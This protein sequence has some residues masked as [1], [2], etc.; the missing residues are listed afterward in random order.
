MVTDAGPGPRPGVIPAQAAAAGRALRDR[1]PRR[2][3][4]A[5]APRPDRPDPV[6]RILADDID[7]LP[8]LLALRHARLAQDPFAY[9]R[10]TAGLMAADL[11][12]SPVT[13]LQVQLCGD[14][15]VANF[16]WFASPERNLVF[17]VTD[18][19]ETLPGPWELDVRRL[20]ASVAVAAIVRGARRAAARDAAASAAAG[21]RAGIAEYAA[22]GTLEAWYA[23]VAAREVVETLRRGS[24]RDR[25][26]AQTALQQAI[27]HDRMAAVAQLTSVMPEG[28]RFVEQPPLVSRDAAADTRAG[29]VE[30]FEAYRREMPPDRLAL[31]GRFRLVDVARKV[32]GVGSIGR[33]CYVALLQSREDDEPL[34]LQAKEAGPS[35]LEAILGSSPLP[36]AERVVVGQRMIQ[37]A[38]DP[39]L[40][41]ANPAS[42]PASGPVEARPG[43]AP[44]G[45]AGSTAR[46]RASRAV[47]EAARTGAAGAG[48]RGVASRPG[49]VSDAD[50][51]P[52]ASRSFYWRQLWDEKGAVPVADLDPVDL[53]VYGAMCARVLARAHARTGDGAQIA[54]YVGSGGQFDAAMGQFAV[55]YADQVL[56]DHDALAAAIRS[57]RVAADR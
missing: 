38:S 30:R 20:V 18:F 55:S 32:V 36:P 52:L 11:A 1:L 45:A 48:S 46:R 41:W 10:G 16:G 5:W 57:G 2:E 6:A 17:D 4:G 26:A 34:V 39:F 25:A 56:R 22:M 53:G 31:L 54:G 19:D 12:A 28:R 21:F 40:G 35:V 24:A 3:L 9:L 27:R 47:S 42:G 15:H 49:S 8:D 13:G 33:R 43:A 7:R 50:A 14:A 37:A 44:A 51:A 23:R 29:V